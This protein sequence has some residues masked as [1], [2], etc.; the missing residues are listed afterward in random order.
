[1]TR[2]IVCAYADLGLGALLEIMV[3][4][5]LGCVPVVNEAEQPIGMVTKLDVVEHLADAKRK[6]D[7]L[8]A[9][10]MMPLA[11]TI[12]DNATVAHAA[13]L[14]AGEDCTTS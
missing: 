1:M 12:E 13:A 2:R 14:M 6:L 10:V 5:R 8:V 7:V 4:D 11:I 9:D 3:Q